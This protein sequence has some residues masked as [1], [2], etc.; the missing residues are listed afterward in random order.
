M[1]TY[2]Y[3]YILGT[4]DLGLVD[5]YIGFNFLHDDRKSLNS[6]YLMTAIDMYLNRHSLYN[7][8]Y[9]SWCTNACTQ[10]DERA[11]YPW[12]RE[13]VARRWW[14]VLCFVFAKVRNQPRV[15]LTG[16]WHAILFP[17]TVAHLLTSKVTVADWN[18]QESSG[19]S[20][21]PEDPEESSGESWNPE[22]TEEILISEWSFPCMGSGI[23]LALQQ[24]CVRWAKW[25]NRLEISSKTSSTLMSG[26]MEKWWGCLSG[27]W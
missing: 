22:E 1:H 21:N 5:R 26:D 16:P 14:D 27:F 12:R 9:L 18:S 15:F 19:E 13:A 8:L 20:W 6:L 11:S 2:I 7:S 10:Q 17:N 4:D 3:I 24:H 23:T 25:A